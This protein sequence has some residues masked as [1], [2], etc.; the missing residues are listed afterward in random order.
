M[1]PAPSRQ[2]PPAR[3]RLPRPARIRLPR[4]VM[5]AK[6]TTDSSS[7]RGSEYS[8]RVTPEDL[9]TALARALT[10]AADGLA[11]PGA[12]D[13]PVE[14]VPPRRPELGDWSTTAALRAAA[15]PSRRLEL[16]DHLCAHLQA[17]PEVASAAIAGPGFVNIT[18]TPAARAQVALDI[19]TAAD[20]VRGA[21]L[22][23]GGFGD[24]GSLPAGRLVA[25]TGQVASVD[26]G[27]VRPLQLGH[28]AVCREERRAHAAGITTEQVD[29]SSLAHPT[30]VRLL[31]ALA[32][33]PASLDR[34]RRLKRGEPLL[35]G[36]SEVSAAIED[37]L[38]HCR[39]TPTIDE[40]ITARHASRLVLARA[41][42]I[43]LAAGL[44]Q[45]GASAP[46]RI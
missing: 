27:A 29:G 13:A 11:A 34:S 10:L 44:R 33:V 35:T 18:L 14:V 21:T 36:L 20:A 24:A 3:I 42:A 41:A 22:R 45:L 4:L 32:A 5:R 6:M 37:W 19:I 28:A 25:D 1:S 46:E 2:R 23:S 8:V 15:R 12:A 16:A 17:L 43:V 9:Q 38:G 40:D 30:E 31:N 26:A 39:V 7:P